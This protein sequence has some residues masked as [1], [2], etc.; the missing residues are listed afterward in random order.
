MKLIAVIPVKEKSERVKNKNTRNFFKN[1]SLLDILVFKLLKIKQINKIYISTNNKKLKKIYNNKKIKII[2]RNKKYCN[3]IAPWSEVIFNVIN[4]LPV[5][6]NTNVMWCHT[7]T[8][9]FDNYTKAIK[10]YKKNLKI[11]KF[12]GLVAVNRLS[13][14]IVTEKLRPLNYTW[15]PWHP[16]SQN[17]DK[18]FSITGALFMTTKEEMLKNRYVISSKPYFFETTQLES[19]DIDTIYDMELAKILYKSKKVLKNI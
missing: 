16:Y 14:F 11:K 7:T 15:G 4:S 12:N 17:L 2:S 9:L 6:K 8:P 10:I 18:L 3:N 19:I 13:Q 5:D 1:K